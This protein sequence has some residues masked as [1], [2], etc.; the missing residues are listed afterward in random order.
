M[1]DGARVLVTGAGGFVGRRLVIALSDD[2]KVGAILALGGVATTAPKVETGVA[3]VTSNELEAAIRTFRPSH[4]VHLAAKSS[5]AASL[6]DGRGVM[7]VS[8]GGALRI[9][10]GVSMHAPNARIL[11]ASSA[12]VYGAA[13]SSGVELDE[14]SPVAPAN[15]Y[16]RSKL[17][18]EFLLM[19]RVHS[20]ASVIVMRPLNHIGPGQDARFVVPAFAQQLAE[21]ERGLRAPEIRVGNLDAQRDFMS[22]DDVVDAYLRAL[23]L[24]TVEPGSR[25]VFNVASG[26]VR[27]IQSVLNDLLSLSAVACSVVVDTDRFR[28][29]DIAITRL[30]SA[31]LKVATGWSAKAEWTALL[32]SVLDDQR[33][34][35]GS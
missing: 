23:F 31:K 25:D 11:F 4:I 19:D 16:A 34:R 20:D 35:L 14:T 10:D 17:V 32:T 22:V 26:S 3:D 1:Q 12:E 18:A 27:S 7:D 2:P 15:P 21:I 28:P 30:S 29:N 24:K 5:V 6:R 13:F 8:V 33:S 9:A